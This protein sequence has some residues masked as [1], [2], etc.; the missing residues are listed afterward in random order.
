MRY[1]SLPPD[2]AFQSVSLYELC[3]FHLEDLVL[4][5]LPYIF[6]LTF[7]LPSLLKGSPSPEKYLMEAS[8]L[9]FSVPESLTPCIMSSCVS[10]YLL[11]SGAGASFSDDS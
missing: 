8:H 7:L 10:M 2:L 11:P 6:A 9:V 3:S 4:L 1:G 5:C